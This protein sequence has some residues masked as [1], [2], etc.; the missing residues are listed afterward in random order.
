[1]VTN[2]TAVASSHSL[3][4]CICNSDFRRFTVLAVV[5]SMVQYCHIL[6]PSTRS[7]TV[8]IACVYLPFLN[9][10]NIITLFV[11]RQ[12]DLRRAAIYSFKSI[13]CKRKHQIQS[14]TVVG[15]WGWRNQAIFPTGW[16]YF[17]STL[18]SSIV[19]NFLVKK[20]SISL[21]S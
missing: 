7:R 21:W 10:F 11:C 4:F 3:I 9:S 16:I 1:M 6:D 15:S 17:V 2:F 20:R 18:I 5:P 8:V 14:T 12:G 19:Y 13:F